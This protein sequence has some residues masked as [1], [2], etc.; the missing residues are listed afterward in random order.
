M[1]GID[2]IAIAAKDL[3]RQFI[4]SLL[5]TIALVI[6]TVILVILIAISLGGSQAIKAQFGDDA[7]LSTIT[8]TPNQSSASLS[9]FG[10]VQEVN[11]HS[12][13]LDDA[14]VS[15]LQSIDHVTLA[16]PRVHLWELHHFTVEGNDKQF[17]AQA[18]GVHINGVPTLQ[19]GDGFVSDTDKNVIIVGSA[20]AK[21]LGFSDRPNELV[22]KSVQLT[23]QKGYRGDGANIP[24][25]NASL[26][27]NDNFNQGDTTL[28]A[29]VVGVTADGI[30]QNSIFLPFQWA[31]AIRTAQYSEAN[32]LKTV[33]QLAT[34]GYT[35]VRVITDST[36]KVKG[37]S[38]AIIKLGYG[39]ISTL[40][41]IE[42]LQQFTALM[43]LVL[44]AVAVIAVIASIL[45]VV[46][47]MLMAV[48]EQRYT[49]GVWRAVGARRVVIVRLFLTQAGL[50]GLLGGAIGAGLALVI[51]RYVNDYAN[52]LLSAQG[53][54]LTNI[55]LVPLWLLAGTIALTTVFGILAG[56]YPAYRAAR[57]DPSA[58]LSSG[59]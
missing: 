57:Q 52:T 12:A 22:G 38:Q 25:A 46:N 30:D 18:E 35:S 45:G 51:S 33:D 53:L 55:A 2:I 5:T 11:D 19:A 4:R 48:S 58:A 56:M 1:R 10:S 14:A 23:T 34:D 50:L 31:H 16:L 21:E 24:P 47:T 54:A 8:V 7:S 9:P 26:Q 29:K 36:D 43:W 44:G 15:S 3:R 41:Q 28:S 27:V 20:Y 37:V 17:V 59:Q 13:K 40:A 42:K 39:Q 32:G 49:V 6:S